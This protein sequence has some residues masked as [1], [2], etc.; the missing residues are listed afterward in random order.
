MWGGCGRIRRLWDW[1]E[2]EEFWWG[3]GELINPNHSLG[4]IE[5]MRS[6]YLKKLFANR[7][8][9]EWMNEGKLNEEAIKKEQIK[10]SRC[11]EW[12]EWGRVPRVW[13]LHHHWWPMVNGLL[14]AKEERGD[15]WFLCGLHCRINPSPLRCKPWSIS[16]SIQIPSTA[17]NCA[18]SRQIAAKEWW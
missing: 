9:R 1:N 17:S 6:A 13:L 12:R 7:I 4:F 8:H 15:G 5:G 16:P 3:E 2:D 18:A 10:N 11:R 14:S